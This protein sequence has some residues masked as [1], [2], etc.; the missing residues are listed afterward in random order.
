M[1]FPDTN[2]VGE[3]KKRYVQKNTTKGRKTA[4]NQDDRRIFVMDNSIEYWY[5]Y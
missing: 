2:F 4:Y 3:N 5:K 1:T